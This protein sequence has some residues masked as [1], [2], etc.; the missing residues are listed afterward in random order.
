MLIARFA[1]E[2]IVKYGIVDGNNIAGLK[3]SPFSSVG[4]DLEKDGTKYKLD[5]VKLLYPCVPGNIVALGLNYRQHIAE[6]GHEAPKSPRVFFKPKSSL[7]SIGENIEIATDGRTEHEAELAIVMGRTAKRVSEKDAKD[8]VFGYTCLNDVSERDIQKA[9]NMPNRA[10]GFDTYTPMGP[11]IATGIDGD[12]L[13]IECLVNG[14]IKQSS[15]TSMLISSVSYLI[16]FIS[17]VMTLFPG[18]VIATGTPEG[19]SPL[20]PGDVVDVRIEKIGTLRNYVV[21]RA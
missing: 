19:V 11:W 2:D 13:K 7:I 21:K 9:D 17:N 6:S 8:Y 3:F 16:A 20:K 12:N 1:H 10:K 18:D 15:N 4:Y 14:Q 5:D